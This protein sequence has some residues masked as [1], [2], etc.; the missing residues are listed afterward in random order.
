M[1][2]GLVATD[3]SLQF[4][5]LT[6]LSKFDLRLKRGN[7]LIVTGANGSGKST[8]LLVCAGLLPSTTGTVLLDGFKSDPSRPSSLFRRG[9][10]RGFVFDNGGLL[11]NHTAL[12]NVTLPLSY[13]ADLLDLDEAKIDL[14]AR[15]ALQEMGLSQ[16]EYH[17]LPA[18]LSLGMRKRV[19]VARVL[20]LE[21]TYVFFDDPFTGL[22]TDTQTLLSDILRR[23]RDD[24]QVTMMISTGNTKPFEHLQLPV[25][26]LVNTF[27]M[28]KVQIEGFGK[29]VQVRQAR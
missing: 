22:D 17:S 16:A 4:G 8:L 29:D 25:F 11:A 13:H 7:S 10:R 5:E 1:A 12:A 21:P 20:A 2:A 3:V 9:V 14:R 6:V 15:N 24:P 23:F 28:E 27:L 18:H 19:S 26:E